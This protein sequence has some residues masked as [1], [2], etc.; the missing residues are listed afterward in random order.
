M[1][2]LMVVPASIIVFALGASI[3]SFINVVVYRLPAKLS[4]L[5]P[6]SRCPRCLNQL[7]AHDNVPVLGW[8]WLRGRC[9]YCKTK[10]SIR[11]PVV[12]GITGIIFLVVF[13]VFHVSILTIS[14]W[15]FCSWLLALSLIDLDTMTLPNALTQSGL[16]V[17]I[18]FQ[19]TIGF[20]SPAGW[21]GLVNHLMMAIVGAV[22]GLWLFDAIAMVGSI[23][24]GKTAM[25]AGDAKLAAMMGV[26][27]GWKYLLLA[28]FIAC[29]VGVIVGGGS[30]LLSRQKVGQKIPFGPSL[31][32]GALITLFSG[33][34][35]LSTYLGLFF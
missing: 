30:M 10:I 7:K 16:V 15:A 19:M 9:R 12:E 29:L 32:L 6:P 34:A 5:W 31:A 28:S 23:A 1:D 24:L 3:G 2:I 8:V 26:W 13:L 21:I 18:C 14:Y 35:I 27:L 11:Y 17:G 33:E 25:G 20:F 22:L 4:V